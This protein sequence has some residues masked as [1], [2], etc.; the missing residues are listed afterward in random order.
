[1]HSLAE[2]LHARHGQSSQMILAGSN[3][4]G[5]LLSLTSN[6]IAGGALIAML[7]PMS[8]SAGIVIVA[9]GVL[10][11]TLWSG[12]RAS[13]LTDFI[14]VC[15]M[16]GAVVIIVPTVFFSAGGTEIFASGGVN[17]TPAQ[18]SFFSSEAFLNQVAPYI[19]IG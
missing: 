9:S 11:Y 8:F 5:S 1:A 4:L 19:E 16:L 12:L 17:L 2:I 18:Q 6:F 10:L 3:I 7:S 13:I 14:Q 15:A